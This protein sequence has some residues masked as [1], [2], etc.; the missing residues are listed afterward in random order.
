MSRLDVMID[1][2]EFENQMIYDKLQREMRDKEGN[3][4]KL[5]NGLVAREKDV[6]LN[7]NTKVNYVEFIERK[8]AGRELPNFRAQG[9][10]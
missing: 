5:R 10:L 2:L 8:L 3:K 9:L 6:D 1:R 7:F 4:L